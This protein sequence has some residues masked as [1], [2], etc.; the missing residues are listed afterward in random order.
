MHGDNFSEADDLVGVPTPRYCPRCDRAV[1][2]EARLCAHC[3]EALREQAFCPVCERY[4]RLPAGSDCPKH[5]IPLDDRAPAPAL[6]PG[7]GNAIRWT[8]IASYYF[9]TQATAP[10]LMLEAEGIATFVDGERMGSN[11]IYPVATGG[12]KLQVPEANVADARV[13]LSQ[14]RTTPDG[15]DDL[16]DAWEELAPAPWDQRGKVINW[17]IALMILGPILLT[18]IV[19]ALCANPWH[20]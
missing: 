12:V 14:I 8:T 19:Q 3:G 15:P 2:G 5:E 6:G 10:R 13:L 4:W 16:D 9:A 20:G 1:G 18:L 11:S 7:A 17:V